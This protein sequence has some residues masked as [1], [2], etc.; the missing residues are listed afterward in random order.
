MRIVSGQY[1]GRK[2]RP[3]KNLPVRPT[4]DYAKEALFNVLENELDWEDVEVLDLFSGTGNISLE[5]ASRGAA[6]V[7]S[8]EQDFK[9]IQFLKKIKADWGINRGKTIRSEVKRFI[10]SN[11]HK[12]DIV[13]ADP[14]YD[15]NWLEEIPT[16]VKEAPMLNPNGMLILE[17]DRRHDFSSLESHVHTRIYGNVHF[18]FFQ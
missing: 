7:W 3:P 10:A 11:K 17:H 15:L 4:T 12:F 18:S 6:E 2:I 14:P 16:L 13:F 8:V 5:F 1:R 9:A